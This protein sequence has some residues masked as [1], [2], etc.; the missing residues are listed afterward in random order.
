MEENIL[1]SIGIDQKQV[2]EA[3]SAA[4]EARREIDKLRLA[5]KELSKAEG[6][7]SVAITKNTLR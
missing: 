4:A 2:E 6:D 1:L 7:N 5:N 3:I